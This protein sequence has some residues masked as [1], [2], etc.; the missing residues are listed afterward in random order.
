MKLCP[1]C[2]NDCVSYELRRWGRCIDCEK[3]KES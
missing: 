1:D 3:E 2:G